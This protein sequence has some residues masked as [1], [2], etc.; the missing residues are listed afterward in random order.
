M[1][2]QEQTTAQGEELFTGDTIGSQF[3]IALKKFIST[4]TGVTDATLPTSDI[5]TNNVSTSKHGFAPKLPNDATKYL[6]GVGAYSVPAGKFGGTGAD[7]ALSGTTNLDLG[8]SAIVVKN[9]TSI[10]M[11]GT[12]TLAFSNAATNGTII[13]LKSQGDVT[14]TTSTA[15]DLRSLGSVG[16]TGGA[17][18]G[19]HASVGSGGGGGASASGSGATGSAGG[20]NPGAD[21]IV[22]GAFGLWWFANITGGTGGFVNGITPTPAGTINNPFSASLA[23][24]GKVLLI[25]GSGGGGGA[26]GA[27]SNGGTGGSGGGAL[28]I[29]CGGALNFGASANIN[30]NGGTGSSNQSG[31]T[32][33]GGGGGGG[34]GSVVILYATLTANAGTI[35]VAGGAGGTL[36][37]ANNGGNGTA[38]FSSIAQNTELF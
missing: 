14:I 19:G 3:A 32:P 22:G 29:E 8:S 33:G 25:P 34:G 36:T 6:N 31:A 1:D 16:G 15:I 27:T 38:G 35:T 10:S 9:F 26:G 37:N 7:G 20:G 4:N 24:Y 28:Y 12:S 17:L 13:I 5:T 30:A 23:K 18:N 2:D 11:T 21:G